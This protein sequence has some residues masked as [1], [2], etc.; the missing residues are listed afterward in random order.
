[1]IHLGQMEG[2]K[3]FPDDV[4]DRH[5]AEDFPK[6][7][8][9][10]NGRITEVIEYGSDPTLPSLKPY[11]PWFTERD[12]SYVPKEQI[13]QF[14]RE[15]ERSKTGAASADAIRRELID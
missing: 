6:V 9:D 10:E 12:R 2:R 7:E 11:L 14:A 13:E 3:N 1:M 5:D 8:V 4:T 15:L